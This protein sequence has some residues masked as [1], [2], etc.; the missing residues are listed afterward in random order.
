VPPSDNERFLLAYLYAA[1]RDWPHARE[2]FLRV[3]A[4]ATDPNLDYLAVFVH[5]LIEQG[6][7]DDAGRW[8]T[9]LERLEKAGPDNHV[10]V[11]TVGLRARLCHAR[12]KDKDAKDLLSDCAA[13][14]PMDA[15]RQLL[16]A[17][18]FEQMGFAS[19]AGSYYESYARL[20][21]K[22]QPTSLIPWISYLGRQDKLDEALNLCE[23][24]KGKVDDETMA[25]VWV[26][27]LR[28]GHPDAKHCDRAESW[29]RSALQKRPNSSLLLLA[30]ANLRD[31]QDRPQEAEK[32]YRD[33][34]ERDPRNLVA[35]NNLAALLAFRGNQ[36]GDAL[37]VIQRAIEV[38]GPMANLLDTRACVHMAL[39]QWH[40]AAKDLE[41]VVSR[42]PNPAGY[43]RLARALLKGGDKRAAQAALRKAKEGG[44]KLAE[45]HP[46]ERPVYEQV[47][48]QLEKN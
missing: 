18:V 41:E 21:G 12:K 11:R 47:L 7:V 10:T 48:A 30:L 25:H 37:A 16:V 15:S 23:Q 2:Q 32:I 13:E 26:G 24:L 19:D 3:L 36:E 14:G 17:N 9:E 35:G 1:N 39:G 33:L 22:E 31:L 44:L 27:C 43:L 38:G 6:E 20:K 34:L 4:G 29:I 28:S 5:L 42:N 8:L 45:L 46:L 40:E